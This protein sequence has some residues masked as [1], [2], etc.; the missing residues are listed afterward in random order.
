MTH[1]ISYQGHQI[2]YYSEG[3]GEILLFLHGWPTNHQLW[4]AQLAHFK[5]RYRVITLDWLGFGASDKPRDFA[6]S[7]AHK[8]AILEAVVADFLPPGGTLSLIAHDIGGPAAIL[9][10]SENQAKL[11]RLV[12]LNTV[13]YPFSTPLDSIS[14]KM[15]VVPGLKQILMSE[16]GHRRL[17]RNLSQSRGEGLNQRIEK[18]LQAHQNWSTDLK[19]KTILDPLKTAKQQEFKRLATLF[20]A[21]NIE[22]QL[23]IAKKDPLCYAHINKLHEE[24]PG[25]PAHFVDQ[26][27][28]FISLDRPDRL[29]EVLDEILA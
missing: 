10:A 24:N 5:T 27:G 9:W 18:V 8:K 6:Y 26:C 1:S 17:L 29:N 4:Q 19:V 22:R 13:I 11:Q 15:F 20:H 3:E 12:L 2:R 14:H 21:M 16:F 28:H 25:V 23:I 7:F